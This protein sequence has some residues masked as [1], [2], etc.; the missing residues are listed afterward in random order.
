MTA[1]RNMQQHN[2][3]RDIDL[4]YK[5]ALQLQQE[6]PPA[7]ANTSSDIEYARK[8][9]E[10]ENK[11][12]TSQMDQTLAKQYQQAEMSNALTGDDYSNS[13]QTM[14]EAEEQRRVIHESDLEL[15]R[16]L[17]QEENTVLES[18][19]PNTDID[20]AL[21]MKLQNEENTTP[22][23]NYKD[24]ELAL[25]LQK[26]ENESSRFQT[27]RTAKDL[28]IAHK[29]QEEMRSND[30]PLATGSSVTMGAATL[31]RADV[32]ETDGPTNKP[33]EWQEQRS[34]TEVFLVPQRDAEW[35]KV[36]QKFKASLSNQIVSIS[37]IQNTWLWDLYCFHRGK[38]HQ[39]NNGA[40]NEMELFHGTRQNDP[41]LIYEGE[42]GFDMRYSNKGMWGMANYFAVYAN[43]SN[44]YAFT[45]PDG[46]KEMFL[47]KVLIGE[48]YKCA[49]DRNLRKPPQKP[50]GSA[51][52]NRL[53]PTMDYDTVTGV[54]SG[55]QVFMTYDN[56]KAYPAYIIKYR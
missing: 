23:V 24:I 26:E 51:E 11:V 8:L 37:R 22:S 19:R 49:P 17:Q 13:I 55:H 10:E 47:A 21:A 2:S 56:C 52:V 25:K 6:E 53:F 34:T 20:V 50:H 39:K 38:L 46:C 40:V 9:Q 18:V 42:Q 32:T 7:A 15:A 30:I 14:L 54:T 27:E 4:D 5:L 28:E 31:P 48:S 12:N 44:T 3:D 41:K 29:L 16:K 1:V 33:P 36:E 43:Y 45:T 35:T